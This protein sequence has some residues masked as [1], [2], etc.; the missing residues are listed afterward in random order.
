MR[1]KKPFKPQP[2]PAITFT[3][4]ADEFITLQRAYG[5]AE[6]TIEAR[7]TAVRSFT[8]FT[9][10]DLLCNDI[11]LALIESYIQHLVA[12]GVKKTTINTYLRRISPIIKYGVSR[13]YI[14]NDFIITK[15]C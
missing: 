13:G 2:P 3:A 15:N 10:A 7:E 14:P 6:S 11:C 9:G 4:A 8:A 5:I 12:H 1:K